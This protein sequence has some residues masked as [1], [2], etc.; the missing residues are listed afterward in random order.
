M[1]RTDEL[2]TALDAVRERV[3]AA[4]RAVGRDPDDIQLLPVTKFFPATDVEELYRLGCRAF[5]ESR[6]QEAAVKVEQVGHADIQWHMVGNLQRNK[7][8]SVAHWAYSVHSVDNPRLVSALDTARGAG[9]TGEPLHVY[10]QISL[11]GDTTRGGV[12]I[13]DLAGIDE[14][15]AQVVASE[16]LE[17]DGLMALPP[18]E[19]DPDQAFRRL[20][21]EQERVRQRYPQ[22]NRLSAGMSNDLET[23]IKYGSTCVRVGTALMGQRPLTSR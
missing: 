12:D 8:K 1:S 15:C 9:E 18:R 4:A 7:A 10:L 5:G 3:R 13:A 11:D 23:A 2:S 14:L 19:A 21:Q 22:A 20:Q 16:H 17:L 6:D